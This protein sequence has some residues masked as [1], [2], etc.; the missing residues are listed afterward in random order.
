MYSLLFDLVGV[1]AVW[2]QPPEASVGGFE[3]VWK[4]CYSPERED[5]YE[6]D[7]GYLV[8]MPEGRFCEMGSRVVTLKSW[9][10]SPLIG[11]RTR[12]AWRAKR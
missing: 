4:M 10:Q 3:G 2:S 7:S 6:I 1:G 9:I 8:L 12:F 5:V 11:R